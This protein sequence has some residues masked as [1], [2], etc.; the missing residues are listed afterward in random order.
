MPVLG[1]IKSEDKCSNPLSYAGTL[2]LYHNNVLTES[3]PIF[4]FLAHKPHQL[5]HKRS[6]SE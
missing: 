6:G 4:A 3:N 5:S 1:I 2:I